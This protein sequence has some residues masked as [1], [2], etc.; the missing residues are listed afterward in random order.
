MHT[1][2]VNT[3]VAIHDSYAVAVAITQ[4]CNGQVKGA[5]V[6]RLN[7][8]DPVEGE[9]EAVKL[10]VKLTC[11]HDF[12]NVILES[13][14]ETDIKAIN[15]WPH[16]TDWRIHSSV[17]KIHAGCRQLQSWK[18]VHAYKDENELAHHFVRWATANIN[19]VGNSLDFELFFDLS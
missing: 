18:A 15:S 5:S 1:I 3:D 10:G 12:A 6:K 2:K 11:N 16:L 17:M 9:V 14:S 7:V 4:D 19:L 13:D 8:V